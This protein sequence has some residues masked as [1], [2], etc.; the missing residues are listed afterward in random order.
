[1][2]DKG[3]QCFGVDII[4]SPI[5]VFHV[6]DDIFDF[7]V[8]SWFDENTFAVHCREFYFPIF[9]GSYFVTQLF[10]NVTEKFVRVL[11]FFED[12]VTGIVLFITV[13]RRKVVYAYCDEQILS[14]HLSLSLIWPMVGTRSLILRLSSYFYIQKHTLKFQPN[15]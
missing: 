11:Q 3:F 14:F 5:F 7:M 4:I 8:I 10:A 15:P 12:V 13:Y 2:F 9:R 1:M 6:A